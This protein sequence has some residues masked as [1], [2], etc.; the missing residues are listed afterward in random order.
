M[1]PTQRGVAAG[2]AAALAVTLAI[3]LWCASGS[4][5][6]VLPFH[7]VGLTQRWTLAG[8][9][10]LGPLVALAAAIGA[11]A[12]RRFV[13][14]EDIDGAGLTLEGSSIR[15]PRAILANTVEQAVLAIPVYTALALFLPV[16]QLPLPALL[17]LAFV[18]GRIAFALGYARGATA[19]SIGFALTFYP[20]V[21]GLVVMSLT[22]A[23]RLAG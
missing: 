17:S 13:S 11:V 7:M 15:V 8:A 5:G 16:R 4:P 9:C 3:T 19:R 10:W 21:A 1:T 6:L 20:T 23:R 12:N 18:I 14:R 2:M 22:L